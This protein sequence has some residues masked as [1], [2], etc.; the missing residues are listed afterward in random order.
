M[1]FY[2]LAIFIFIFFFLIVL[3]N[4]SKVSI[5]VWTWFLLSCWYSVSALEWSLK[6]HITPIFNFPFVNLSCYLLQNN[7][8]ILLEY[9]AAPLWNS[10]SCTP[11]TSMNTFALIF[12]CLFVIFS[13]PFFRKTC[14]ITEN[15][16]FCFYNSN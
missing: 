1:Q 16:K 6:Q 8:N 4:I 15:W 2:I 7:M 5:L 11:H 3:A 9:S 10:L 13:I 14:H 12:G